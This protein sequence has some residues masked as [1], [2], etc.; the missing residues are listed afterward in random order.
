MFHDKLF[1]EF[2][3]QIS[4]RNLKIIK[5]NLLKWQRCIAHQGSSRLDL[6]TEK[7]MQI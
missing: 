1:K 2:Q 6:L 3:N 4:Y 7:Q 5:N